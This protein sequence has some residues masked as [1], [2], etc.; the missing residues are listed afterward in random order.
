MRLN[1]PPATILAVQYG[2]EIRGGLVQWGV[3]ALDDEIRGD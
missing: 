2:D 1:K 3:V